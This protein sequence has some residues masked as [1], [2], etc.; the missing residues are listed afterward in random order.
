[1]LAPRCFVPPHQLLTPP[2]IYQI[3]RQV[4]YITITL[5]IYLARDNVLFFQ[6]SCAYVPRVRVP[7]DGS[8][9]LKT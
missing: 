1:M 5:S 2:C 6:E 9:T 8:H 3:R 4:K 7:I